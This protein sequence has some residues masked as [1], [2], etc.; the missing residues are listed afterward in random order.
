MPVTVGM[1]RT[2]FAR[3]EIDFWNNPKTEHIHIASRDGTTLITTVND[4]PRSERRH[5]NM[6]AKLKRLLQENNRWPEGA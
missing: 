4:K 5:K 1:P 2:K 6:F 3:M